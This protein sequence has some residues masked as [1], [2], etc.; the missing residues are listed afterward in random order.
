MIQAT[1]IQALLTQIAPETPVS[2]QGWV[3]TR[4]EL[5]DLCFL[6]LN[7]G[8]CLANLQILVPR[9]SPV[10]EVATELHTGAAIRVTGLLVASPA[11]GQRV[12]LHAETITVYGN[13]DPDSYP[14]QK[15]RH[16]F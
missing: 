7:D 12:E 3:R 10:Y 13:A 11:K 8:S 1:P 16:S 6:E 5:K 2:A 14:L 9:T 15:K 4:R